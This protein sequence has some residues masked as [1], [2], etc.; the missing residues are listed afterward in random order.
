MI[1]VHLSSLVALLVLMNQIVVILP[2]HHPLSVLAHLI[3]PFMN[4][5]ITNMV[6]NLHLDIH[7]WIN[8]IF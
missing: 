7:L 2:H 6:V 1:W 5:L 8:L 3:K 4:A